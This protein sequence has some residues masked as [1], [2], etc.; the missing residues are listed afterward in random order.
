MT[1]RE[2]SNQPA[3]RVTVKV[4]VAPEVAPRFNIGTR[5][6]VVASSLESLW[7]GQHT[8]TLERVDDDG[9]T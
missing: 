2:S 7:Q 6:E 1:G 9:G 8:V 5:W 4:T 3:R